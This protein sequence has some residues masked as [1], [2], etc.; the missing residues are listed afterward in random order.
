VCA[1]HSG[2]KSTAQNIVGEARKVFGDEPIELAAIGPHILRSSFEVGRDVAAQLM[3]AAPSGT[4]EYDLSA[5]HPDPKK[6]YFDLTELVRLQLR[7]AFGAKIEIVECLEDTKQ[8]IQFHSFRR[9]RER[10]ERQYSFVVIK[11]EKPAGIGS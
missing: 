7:S 1:I 6:V 8:S 4:T 2:W 9:D 3:A 10:A 11:P 5:M